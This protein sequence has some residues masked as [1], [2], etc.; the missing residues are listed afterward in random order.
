[1]ERIWI[2]EENRDETGQMQPRINALIHGSG[3]I[4]TDDQP[5]R[6]VQ[7]SQAN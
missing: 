7:H 2:G 4:S 6:M 1:M 5:P 3:K